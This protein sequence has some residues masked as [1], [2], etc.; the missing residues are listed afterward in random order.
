MAGRWHTR[1]DSGIRLDAEGRFWHDGEP[2]AN[3]NVSRAFHR[4]LER[5]DDGRWLVR[6]GWDWAYIQLDDAP[7]QVL[8]LAHAPERITLRLDDETEEALLPSTLRA[9]GE[10][11]LYAQVKAGAAEARFSRAA[12]GQLADVLDERDGRLVLRLG[13]ATHPIGAR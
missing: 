9:S 2:I 5:A 4:G 1:E 8:G 6:F 13:D 11:V 12:Q 10:G 7:Y 3:A